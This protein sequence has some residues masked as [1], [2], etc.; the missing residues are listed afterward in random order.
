MKLWKLG[1]KMHL[2][3]YD[4]KKKNKPQTI[5]HGTINSSKISEKIKIYLKSSCV[6]TPFGNDWYQSA[7]KDYYRI[8]YLQGLYHKVFEQ[9]GSKA[10][11]GLQNVALKV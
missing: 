11:Q 3:S 2:N 5:P 9:C 1:K 10:L 6:T 7:G 4:V 8:K